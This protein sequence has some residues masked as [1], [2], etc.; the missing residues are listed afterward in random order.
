[1]KMELLPK[2]KKLNLDR[3]EIT[4][5]HYDEID[6]IYKINNNLYL[7]SLKWKFNV[8]FYNFNDPSKN[9]ILQNDEI[10]D[11]NNWDLKC[12]YQPKATDYCL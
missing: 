1:M 3:N 11:N 6:T 8:Y 10:D 4:D 5:I 9:K 12:F 7:V 2:E